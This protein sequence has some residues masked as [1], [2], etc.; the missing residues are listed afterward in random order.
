MRVDQTDFLRWRG[1]EKS[2]L[3]A[4]RTVSVVDE[5]GSEYYVVASCHSTISRWNQRV[6]D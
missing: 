1:L 4:S 3:R 5:G 6:E 2:R